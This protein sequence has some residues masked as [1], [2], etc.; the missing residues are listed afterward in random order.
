MKKAVIAGLLLLCVF[1]AYV[2]GNFYATVAEML[3]RMS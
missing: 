1:V 2:I 3:T